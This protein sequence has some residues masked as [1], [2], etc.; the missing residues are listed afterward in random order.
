MDLKVISSTSYSQKK[1]LRKSLKYFIIRDILTFWLQHDSVLPPVD[2]LFKIIANIFHLIHTWGTD[3]TIFE[4][5]LTSRHI[6][7]KSDMKEMPVVTSIGEIATPTP[8]ISALN[9]FL[10]HTF[11]PELLYILYFLTPGN[12]FSRRSF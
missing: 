2:A 4:S 12:I 10:V 11:L 7:Y 8:S 1:V 5:L 6:L 3:L 9:S